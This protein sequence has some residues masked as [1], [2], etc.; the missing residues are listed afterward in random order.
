MKM[1]IKRMAVM[2]CALALALALPCMSA[3][4]AQ[5][6]VDFTINVDTVT[7][8]AAGDTV[9]TNLE[10]KTQTENGYVEMSMIMRYNADTF[11]YSSTIED[12][13]GFTVINNADEGQLNIYYSSPDGNRSPI[14]TYTLMIKFAVKTGVASGK[15]TFSLDVDPKDVY[16]FD[17]NGNKEPGILTVSNAR[18]KELTVIETNTDVTTPNGDGSDYPGYFAPTSATQVAD[19][20][21]SS[22][23]SFGSVLFFI[24]GAIVIFGAG[25]FVGFYLAQKRMSEENL[26][27]N[28]GGGSAVSAARQGRQP[29]GRGDRFASD[30]DDA[31]VDPGDDRGSESIYDVLDKPR[32]ARSN[33]PRRPISFE[34]DDDSRVDTG[35]FGKAATTRI[36]DASREVPDFDDDDDDEDDGFPASFIPRSARSQSADRGSDRDRGPEKDPYGEFGDFGGMLGSRSRRTRSDD[37][38]GSFTIDDEDPEDG[39][40]DRRRYR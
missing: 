20:S 38:Y 14:D 4:A 27:G 23:A 11:T 15:Y 22:C 12:L 3:S 13:D 37:G 39:Y 6:D 1:H 31:P 5:S 7:E 8:Y 26:Y 18:D 16:G 29:A 21:G 30:D 32:S 33:A 17:K 19:K 10:I 2:L 24:I 28:F 25:F 35:Y 40:N 34:T 9:N 36:G